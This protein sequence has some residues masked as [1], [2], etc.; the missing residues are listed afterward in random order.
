MLRDEAE[1]DLGA[2]NESLEVSWIVVMGYIVAF[3]D[4]HIYV[5]LGAILVTTHRW[6]TGRRLWNRYAY[7]CIV[8]VDTTVNY[9]TFRAY[10]LML[11]VARL[12][13]VF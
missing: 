12:A 5:F 9:K 4:S 10:C 11:Q 1:V 8:I 7:H 13:L 6:L 2:E 3:L